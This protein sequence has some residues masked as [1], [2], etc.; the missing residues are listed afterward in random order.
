MRARDTLL[1]PGDRELIVRRLVERRDARGRLNA[2]DVADAARLCDVDRATMWRWV[3]KGTARRVVSS[4]Y[5]LTERDK[6][7]FFAANGNY[8][9]AYEDLRR[10]AARAPPSL[11]TFRRAIQREWDAGT[12]VAARG[13]YAARRQHRVALTRPQVGR[14]Q[15]WEADHKRL[16]VL[17]RVPGFKEPRKPWVTWVVDTFSRYICGWAVSMQPT[18][19]EVLAVIRIACSKE[20]GEGPVHGVPNVLVWDNGLEFT[21]RAVSEAGAMIGSYASPAF[22][23]SPEQKGSIERLNRTVTSEFLSKMPYCTAGPTAKDRKL[24][25]PGSGPISLSRFVREFAL[26]VDHYN[27]ERPHRQL[28]GRTPMQAWTEDETPIRTVPEEDLRRFTLER[29][30]RTVRHDGGVHVFGRS[31]TAPEL[32]ALVRKRVE[33]GSIPRDFGF[34]EVFADDRWICTAHPSDELTVEQIHKSRRE[35]QRLDRES[36]RLIRRRNRLLEQRFAPMTAVAP[37]P[38]TMVQLTAAE[39]SSLSVPVDRQD[40]DVLGF[41]S[42]IGEVE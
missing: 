34:V 14:N 17:V 3:A 28:Q 31:Y 35:A 26:W 11:S 15:R 13:G 2:G 33:V 19:G 4:R 24:Y 23:Y 12:I 41:G 21:A 27:F 39:V 32:H 10:E 1:T 25:G 20:L 37:E 6:V 7:A 38:R 9:Q 16:E 36:T 5:V 42:Q 40:E 8:R 18:R 22:A 29:T 30:E